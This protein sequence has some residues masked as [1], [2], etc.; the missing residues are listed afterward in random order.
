MVVKPKSRKKSVRDFFSL[1]SDSETHVPDEYRI[2]K[3][4]GETTLK[5]L[6]QTS[7]MKCCYPNIFTSIVEMDSIWIC[8]VFLTCFL[9]SWFTFAILYFVVAEANGDVIDGVIPDTQSPCIEGVSSFLEIFQFSMETQTT[10]GYGTRYVTEECPSAILL[11]IVQSILGSFILSALTG[12]VFFKFQEPKKRAHTVL[13][14][15]VACVFEDGDKYFIEV[16]I[17]NMQRSQVIDPKVTA[18]CIMN[19]EDGSGKCRLDMDFSPCH[20]NSR[21]FFRP[22]VYRHLI[23][24]NSPF[25]E[26]DRRDFEKGVYEIIVMIDGVDELTDSFVRARTSFLPSEIMWSRHFKQMSATRN[27]NMFKL[28]FNDFKLTKMALNMSNDSASMASRKTSEVSVNSEA[29][30]EDNEA[31]E[32]EMSA[33]VNDVKENGIQCVLTMA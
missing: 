6:N 31:I 17:L 24:E 3:Q 22:R 23:D 25:W 2:V 4:K 28:N 19:R 33:F 12:V 20:K 16:Q 1:N 26:F 7:S 10:I 21:L 13:F 27:G 15:K 18:I 32:M 14:S 11:V 8:L 9:L 30:D 5:L 29:T